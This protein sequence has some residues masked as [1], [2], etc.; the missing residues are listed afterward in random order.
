MVK[1]LRDLNVMEII[2]G[3]KDSH[4]QLVMRGLELVKFLVQQREF[5]QQYLELVWTAAH[6][7]EE[8]TKLE[9]YNIFKDVSGQLSVSELESIIRLFSAIEPEKFILREIE[10][11]SSLISYANRPPQAVQLQTQLFFD[12]AVQNRPYPKELVEIAIDKLIG[13]VR[14]AQESPLRIGFILRAYETLS[15]HRASI[16]CI[17]VISKILD[18]VPSHRYSDN[19]TRYEVASELID[20][21]K[22]LDL[23]IADLQMYSEAVNQL[24]DRGEL[25][26]ETIDSV[27][28]FRLP[29]T[30]RSNVANRLSFIRQLLNTSQ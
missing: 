19:R 13:T 10:C 29:F 5:S 17:R 7:G 4:I 25:K 2:F 28:L 8:Q 14:I 18:E 21:Y 27:E 24:W 30:H 12:I 6:R 26:R 23:V 9:I 1:R 15:D 16:Q 20:Q 11:L 3:D 22:L